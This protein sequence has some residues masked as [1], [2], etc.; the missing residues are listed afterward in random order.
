[1]ARYMVRRVLW[2]ILMLA[3]VSLV[4]FVIFYVFPSADPAQL[5]RPDARLRPR[6]WT[7]FATRWGSS[8]PVYTQFWDYMKGHRALQLRSRRYSFISSNEPV[9]GSLI[10]DR[11]PATIWLVTGAAILWPRWGSRWESSRQSSAA[12]CS[13]GRRW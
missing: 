6:R 2:G 10:F 12:R 9:K 4:V 3:I 7:L 1:M 5:R 13:T 11:L 8:K